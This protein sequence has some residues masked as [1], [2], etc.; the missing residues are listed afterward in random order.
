MNGSSPYL[1]IGRDRIY[2][3]HYYEDFGDEERESNYNY[4]LDNA[5]KIR[6]MMINGAYSSLGGNNMR[7]L[8]RK[9]QSDAHDLFELY[10][11]MKGGSKFM[12]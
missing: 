3:Q 1:F 9:V 8:E 10:T 11:K 5:E 7:S 6:N 4:V 2:H 12:R